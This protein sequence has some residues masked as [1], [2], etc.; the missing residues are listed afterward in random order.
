MAAAVDSA[1]K[2]GQSCRT[3]Y[4]DSR[5]ARWQTSGYLADSLADSLSSAELELHPFMPSQLQ[6]Q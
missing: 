6:Q 3:G 4:L 2:L 1:V 5:P